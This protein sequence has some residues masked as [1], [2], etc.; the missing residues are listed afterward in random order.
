MKIK[1][2]F[3]VLVYTDLSAKAG[4]Q[5]LRGIY[6]FLG[7]GYVWDMSLIRSQKEFDEKFQGLVVEASFD[8][9]L[10]GA[11][12]SREIRQLHG[13]LNT[14]TV[15]IDYVDKNLEDFA[16]CVFVHDDDRDIG[17]C[18]AQYLMSQGVIASYGYAASSDPRPWNKIRGEVF[19]AS[20]ARRSIPVSYFPEADTQPVA[21]IVEWLQSLPKPAGILAAYDD[22]ARRILNVCLSA[23]LRVPADVF[24]LGIGNDEL[25]CPQTTPPLSSVIP[26]FEE[27]GYRAARELQALMIGRR[28]PTQ[29]EIP[30]GCKG[31]AER[32]TTLRE[33]SAAMLVQQAMAFIKENAY[34]G[35]STADVVRHLHVSRRLADLRFR[36]V[37]GTSILASITDLRLKK[38]KR[39]LETTD[40]RMGEIALRCGY[41]AANLKNLFARHFKC[42]MRTYRRR[43]LAASRAQAGQARG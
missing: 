34:R 36:Q 35:I 6:R 32:G 41:D 30:C 2:V 8:G 31:V 43:S 33:K 15:F 19:S 1:D 17:R 28:L 10:M 20:L 24:I 22:T 29:R 23:G 14:P 42:S 7:S 13:K 40:L 18:A 12:Q 5:R 27:E 25:I 38:V 9:F 3:R 11:P 37:T 21:S 4:R 39:L 16:Q 26:G